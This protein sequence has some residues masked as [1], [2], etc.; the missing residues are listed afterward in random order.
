MGA[1]VS[2][3]RSISGRPV[4]AAGHVNEDLVSELED[5]LRMAK[6]GEICTIAWA[7]ADANGGNKCGW[8]VSPEGVTIA[9]GLVSLMYQYGK[10]CSE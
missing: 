8:S 4:A 2:N 3:V 1:E 5:L 6:N 10:A 9:R 7:S